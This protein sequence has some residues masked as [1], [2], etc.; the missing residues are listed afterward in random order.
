MRE[1][2]DDEIQALMENGARPSGEIL[3]T[4]EKG[5]IGAY[6]SLF[7]TLGKEPAQGLPFNFATKVT[8]Q[9][10][11]KARRKSDIRFNLAAAFILIAGLAIACGL[12]CLVN[13]SAGSQFL[14]VTL[15]YKWVII[16]GAVVLLSTFFFDQKFITE[17]KP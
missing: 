14:V 13:Y 3:S 4:S 10:K 5:N 9:V 8:A 15:K 17:Q 1:L 16:T 2:N 7:K 6:E 11:L 12:L